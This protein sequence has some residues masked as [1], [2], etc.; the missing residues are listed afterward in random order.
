MDVFGTIKNG[1]DIAHDVWR[2]LE[3]I[4]DAPEVLRTLQD[5]AHSMEAL[6]KECQQIFDGEDMNMEFLPLLQAAE[7]SLSK[8]QS[9]VLKYQTK[10][11]TAGALSTRTA[12]KIHLK[13]SKLQSFSQ[14]LQHHKLT[15][16]LI[17]T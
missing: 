11:S 2:L 6:L 3:G 14:D 10:L 15:L 1:I 12:L 13:E 9:H 7:Q 8:L 5:E 16:N 4:K 17:C